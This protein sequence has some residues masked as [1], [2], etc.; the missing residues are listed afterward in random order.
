M[1]EA[2]HTKYGIKAKLRRTPVCDQQRRSSQKGR[3]RWIA[4]DWMRLR[5]RHACPRPRGACVPTW[6]AFGFV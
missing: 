5:P 1:R 4:W 3:A 6:C 2:S